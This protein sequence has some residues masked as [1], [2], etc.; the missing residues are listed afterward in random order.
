MFKRK[1]YTAGLTSLIVL[2][3]MIIFVIYDGVYNSSDFFNIALGIGVVV[4]P[5]IFIYGYVCSLIADTLSEKSIRLQKVTSFVFHLAFG[6]LFIFFYNVMFDRS[7]NLFYE[8]RE[9]WMLYKGIGF[10]A[11]MTAALFWI[12][13]YA[14]IQW[15]RR[16][17][18]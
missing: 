3:T 4:V 2:L 14:L 6:A 7:V 17:T 18:L 9:F 1:L 15:K 13:D 12:V 16:P 10:I 5:T 8:F 11:V